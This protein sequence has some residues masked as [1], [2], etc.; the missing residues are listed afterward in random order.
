MFLV[1]TKVHVCSKIIRRQSSCGTNKL[2]LAGEW[3]DDA[4]F[5][6]LFPVHHI[7]NEHLRLPW[8]RCTL[9]S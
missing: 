7:D 5:L 2:G 9:S 8:Q 6:F 4:L 3:K 1:E